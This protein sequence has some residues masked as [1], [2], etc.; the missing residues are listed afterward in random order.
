M[1]DDLH[2]DELN[3]LAYQ[4]CEFAGVLPAAPS[5]TLDDAIAMAARVTDLMLAREP[6]H[7]GLEPLATHR[8]VLTAFLQAQVDAHKARAAAHADVVRSLTDGIRR[9]RKAESLQRLGRQARVSLCETMGFDQALL[10]F[11]EADGFVV[12]ESERG[13]G[14]PTVVPRRHCTSEREC[15]HTQETVEA[16]D[17]AVSSESGYRELLGTGNYL[18]APILAKSRVVALLHVTKPRGRAIAIGEADVLDAFAAAYSLLYEKILNAERLQRQH[19]SIAQAAE[20]LAEQADRIAFAA[21]NFD[22]DEQAGDEIPML[23]IDSALTA[24]LSDREHD[25]FERLVL[26]ASNADIA[27]TLVITIETVKTHVKRILRKIGAV[28]RAEAIAL[29][30]DEAKPST[31]HRGGQR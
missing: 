23:P 13:I 21:I 19:A 24:T 27:E 9:M 10:S 1:S 28:N 25:V 16:T 26:G 31:R 15:I 11:V 3:A 14:G 18:V 29:Y 7:D 4:L 20:R 5:S 17:A 22:F 8:A 12:E 30:L 6:E 2:V